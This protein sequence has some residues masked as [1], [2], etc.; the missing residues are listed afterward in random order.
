MKTRNLSILAT[1]AMMSSTA[2]AQLADDPNNNSFN[3][4][5]TTPNG[6]V[7]SVLNSFNPP[8]PPGGLNVGLEHDGNGDLLNT[9]IVADDFQTHNA[10]D[11]TNVSG[12]F[13]INANSAGSIGITTDGTNIYVTDTVDDDVDTYSTAG[14]YVSSFPTASTFPEG[15]TIGS[16]DG[17]FYVVDGGGGNVVEQY[18]PTGTPLSTFPILGSSPDGIAF[19]DARCSF[20]IYDSG[21]DTVR[22]YDNTFNEISNFA[23]SGAAG[24]GNGEGLA[25]IGDSLFVMA[26]GS[27]TVVE[28]DISGATPADNAGELCNTFADEARFLV[29]KNFSD[30]NEASVEVT[31]SCNTGLPLS[32]TTTIEEG[33]PVNFVVGDFNQ[34][35]LDCTV[36]E[37]GLDGYTA[38][39]DN[40]DEVTASGCAYTDTGGTQHSCLIT[41]DLNAVTVTVTKEWVDDNPSFN[42]IN[43]ADAEWECN[44]VAEG[45][46]EGNLS[47]YAE[48]SLTDT[49]SFS[50]FPDWDTGTDCDITEVDLPDGGVEVD[51]ASCQNLLLL[52]GGG[53]S[54]TI[55]NTRLYEG[56]PTL[57]QY[58]LA[59]MALLMLGVGFVGFRR[60]V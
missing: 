57:S 59:I 39:Y 47:F 1:A 29:Q 14:A 60:F 6:G 38:S 58:G 23:G 51:D 40:G 9:E 20:W 10:T 48:G 11:G 16:F 36:T 30:D 53:A 44:N 52:P 26:T 8:A 24:F 19:D 5:G 55:V 54:C 32:Q 34:G 3:V 25:V 41:N 27:N 35:E 49:D 15:I 50:V 7:G 45:A 21:T 22:Q 2:F 33:D 43:I 17:N 18:D 46:D 37:G 31:L 56:I 12:P 13:N 42:P 28:F 4:T